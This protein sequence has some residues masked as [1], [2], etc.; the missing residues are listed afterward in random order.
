MAEHI[1]HATRMSR[2]ATLNRHRFVAI[3]HHRNGTRGC[4]RI[5]PVRITRP[6]NLAYVNVGAL[7]FDMPANIRR[8][9]TRSAACE[10]RAAATAKR[11]R[12][13]RDTGIRRSD[14]SRGVVALLRECRSSSVEISVISRRRC[15]NDNRR[16]PRY[17]C[18]SISLLRIR[19]SAPVHRS[20]I[21][22]SRNRHG[23]IPR[24]VGRARSVGVPS[25]VHGADFHSPY[26]DARISII[27]GVLPAAVNRAQA[28][29][30]RRELLGSA[31]VEDVE[32][33]IGIP[34]YRYGNTVG[35][36][37]RAIDQDAPIGLHPIGLHGSSCRFRFKRFRTGVVDAVADP[38]NGFFVFGG[39]GIAEDGVRDAFAYR[40][41]LLDG[42]GLT[43]KGFLHRCVSEFV[44]RRGSFFGLSRETREDRCQRH[45]END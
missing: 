31:L 36:Q 43:A 22:V 40:S 34:L 4:A 1:G 30:R 7:N 45:D 16:S 26:P 24:N 25:P 20:R 29:Q 39:T 14:R 42:F 44:P 10:F 38:V 21:D 28:V 11:I 3:D 27:R 33:S 12:T 32:L 35:V 17:V 15:R 23:G 5:G 13:S 37:G 41:F 19:V 6:V 18:R 9:T 8:R 2:S